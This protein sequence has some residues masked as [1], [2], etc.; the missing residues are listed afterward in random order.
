[1]FHKKM[2]EKFI[3]KCTRNILLSFFYSSIAGYVAFLIS[4]LIYFYPHIFLH[5]VH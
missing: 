1:M 5:Q 2:L 4:S 3:V